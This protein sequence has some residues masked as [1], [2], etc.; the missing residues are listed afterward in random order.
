MKA[1]YAV[2]GNRLMGIWS[3]WLDLHEQLEGEGLPV[4][5][6]FFSAASSEGPAG[7]ILLV[8]K[9]T[10]GDWGTSEFKS[11]SRRQKKAIIRDRL[12]RNRTF[13]DGGA[14]NSAF[15]CFYYRLAALALGADG[16]IWSNVAK[17]GRKNGNPKGRLLT[18]QTELAIRTLQAEIAEYRPALT[19]FVAGSDP[20]MS[21]IIVSALNAP[22]K[23]W[24]KSERIRACTVP[25]VWWMKGETPALWTQHPERKP[26]EQVNFWL[27]RARD[28][29]GLPKSSR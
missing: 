18:M 20:V 26:A 15:W 16:V 8:G 13:I 3:E 9:A 1:P 12:C 25:D 24:T 7:P 29:A 6:P 23:R 10:N 5:A 28:L 4:T 22:A 19:V 11:F 17:I 2:P 27:H 14:K 21:D